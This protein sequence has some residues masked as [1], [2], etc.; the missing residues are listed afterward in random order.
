MKRKNRFLNWL[1]SRLGLEGLHYQVPK[2]ANTIFYALGGITLG[3]I[4]IL[5]ITGFYLAQF[6]NPD[7]AH[8]RDSVLYIMTQV[9]FGAFVRSIHW[10]AANI[11]IIGVVLHLLRIVGTAAYKSP[12]ELNWVFGVIMLL[13][14]VALFF[15]GTVLKWDQEGYEAISHVEEVGEMLGWLGTI[16]TTAYTAS[17]PLLT[18]VAFAHT[19][20]FPITLVLF[21]ALHL[22]LV[23]HHGISPLPLLTEKTDATAYEVQSKTEP[24]SYFDVHFRQLIGYGLLI[25][26]LAALLA[27]LAPAALGEEVVTGEEVTKPPWLFLW[28]VALETWWGIRALLWASII[29]PLVILIV[30]FLDRTPYRHILNRKWV[31]VLSVMVLL[32]WL[33]LTVYASVIP[34]GEHLE[35]G[36][37]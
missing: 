1:D 35:F 20:I 36:G 17:V 22:F 24:I 18:R 37:S 11:V 8:A 33:A 13:F 10:W 16:V 9:R 26:A 14:L 34:A 2:H 7:P 6:Y 5:F 27:L 31:L 15:T 12:R 30:P 19:A 23:K 3:A 32:V 28:L 21:T 29:A 4:I 25:A